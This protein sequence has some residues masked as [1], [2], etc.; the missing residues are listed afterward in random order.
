MRVFWQHGCN[1]AVIQGCSKNEE[2]ENL[3]GVIAVNKCNPH[4][5]NRAADSRFPIEELSSVSK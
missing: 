2:W 4:G 1:Q 5:F 3:E